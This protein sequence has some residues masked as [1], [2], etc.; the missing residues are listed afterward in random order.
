MSI[1]AVDKNL[2]VENVIVNYRDRPEGSESKLNTYSDGIRV[3]LTI[4]NLFRTY[5]PFYFFAVIA[6]GLFAL[7]C[8]FGTP[9]FI[10]YFRTGMVPRFPTL[11]VCGFVAIAAIQSLFS[12]L[13]LQTIRHKNR[14][15]FEL[16][17]YRVTKEERVVGENDKERYRD[18][19]IKD[20]RLNQCVGGIG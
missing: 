16:L 14:Q 5:R 17:L 6:A 9:V 19:Q 13:I 15:D 2:S 18:E 7:S 1:H 11:I 4:L 12:G 20:N 3:L 8:G 10:T